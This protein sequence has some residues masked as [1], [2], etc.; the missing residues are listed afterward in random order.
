M[1]AIGRARARDEDRVGEDVAQ[2]DAGVGAQRQRRAADVLGL[3]GVPPR[4][5]RVQLLDQA[6]R[7]RHRVAGANHGQ[8][9]AARVELAAGLALDD[10]EI[11][12]ALAVERQRDVILVEAQPRRDGF[13]RAVWRPRV[14]YIPA[15]LLRCGAALVQRLELAREAHGF[16][17]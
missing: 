13:T 11:A 14:R 12:V 7:H 5:M 9:V 8:L 3:I 17:V 6:A 16:N 2:V 10:L 15:T 1:G 4:T